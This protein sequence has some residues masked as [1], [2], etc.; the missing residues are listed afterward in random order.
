MS[1]QVGSAS[2]RIYRNNASVLNRYG[3]WFLIAWLA[4]LADGKILLAIAISTLTYQFLAS[5]NQ[6]PWEKLESLYQ[7][8]CQRLSRM[9]QS[10]LLISSLAFGTTYWF[11]A[12]WSQLGGGW[13]AVTLLS[14]GVGNGLFF[15]REINAQA[16][17]ST[18]SANASL[19]SVSSTD[20][21]PLEPMPTDWHNLSSASPL[22]RLLAVRSLLHEVLSSD[23]SSESYLPGTPVTA[24][25][26]L[27]D[28][29]RIMLTHES[30][31]LV[32]VALIEALKALQPKP[33]LPAGQ[34]AI[35][36]LKS[37]SIQAEVNR[38]VEYVELD[39]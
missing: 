3:R 36:P 8:L 20:S 23:N 6:L 18:K 21:P 30:E 14:L 4:A 38:V 28:C 34:P 9:G 26:H 7:R 37:H 12:A 16:K 15:L 31:P 13:A 22:Q 25:S 17:A 35:Q 29:F 2:Q 1:H 10:P 5:G 32:R 33:Q 11:A 19:D 24:R 39:G 27:V